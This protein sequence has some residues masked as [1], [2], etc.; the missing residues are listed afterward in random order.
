MLAANKTLALFRAWQNALNWLQT[1]QHYLLTGQ[2]LSKG[3]N[4]TTDVTVTQLRKTIE[5]TEN[6]QKLDKK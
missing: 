1:Q 5:N 4:V 6:L 3:H 2:P